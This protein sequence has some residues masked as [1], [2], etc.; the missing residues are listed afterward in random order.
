[1]PTQT[2]EGTRVS[3]EDRI[4]HFESASAFKKKDLIVLMRQQQ[5]D[6]KERVSDV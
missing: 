1:M 6:I 2:A 5:I 3:V 4:L